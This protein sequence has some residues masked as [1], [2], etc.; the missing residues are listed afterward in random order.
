MST[1]NWYRCQI[2]LH[3]YYISIYTYIYICLY[4]LYCIYICMIFHM[5]IYIHIYIHIHTYIY[6]CQVNID[7]LLINLSVF[8]SIAVTQNSHR[9]CVNVNCCICF[10]LFLCDTWNE[11]KKVSPGE[12]HCQET[13]KG[14]S[15]NGKKEQ[16]Q[17]T[18]SG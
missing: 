4:V 15:L 9:Y 16:Q 14:I 1:C 12:T 18:V 5:N 3:M 10:H 7:L 17:E 2:T 6:I 8:Q 13:K 11:R